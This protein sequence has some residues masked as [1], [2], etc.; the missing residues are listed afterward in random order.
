MIRAWI[1]ACT[2]SRRGRAQLLAFGLLMLASVPAFAV[3]CSDFGG[4]LDGNFDSAPS[5]MQIDMHCTIRNFPEGNELNTNFSFFTQPGQTDERWIVIFDNVVHTGNMSC[6]ATHEHKIWFTNGSST[7]IKEGCQN[8][9][10]PV[11]KIDKRNPDGQN[12]ARV[13]VPFTYTLTIPV[14][15]DPATSTVIN[16]SGSPNELHSVIVWDDLNETGAD[17]T[18]LGHV[19][20]WKDSGIPV[21]HTFSNVGG[22]LTFIIDPIIPAETQMIIELTVVLDDTPANAPGTQFVNTAKWEFGR[23]IDGEFF[24]PLPGEWGITEP[25]IIASPDLVVTKTGLATMNLGQLGSFTLDVHNA[26]LTDAWDVTILD[27]LPDGASGGM[28]DFTPIIA[29]AQVFAADG[30]TPV[31]GKGPLVE[32]TDYTLGFDG[33]PTC[34][35][36]F[37]MQTPAARIGP[38]ERLIIEYQTK[39]DPDTQHGV[40]LTNVAGAIEWFDGPDS[41][42]V[43]NTVTRTLT[44][45]T[46]GTQDHEDE[47]TVTAALSGYFYEKTVEN[48][49]TGVSPA[50]TASPGDVLRYTLRLQTT[51]DAFNDLVFRDDLGALN[52]TPVFVPGTLALVPGSLP[53]GADASNTNPNGGTDGA[54]F[55]DVRNLD[56]PAWSEISIQFDIAV[57]PAAVEGTVATNQAELV[58]GGLLIAVSDDPNVNGQADPDVDGD[59]DPTRVLIQVPVPDPL[60]KERT[61]ATATIG[62]TFSY[63]ITVPSQPHEEPIYDVRILDDLS[64]SAADLRFVSV[65]KVSGSQP[66]TP[67]NIGTATSLVIVDP[68]VGIDIPAG[69]QI[70]VEITVV[71]E[72]TPGNVAGVTFTNTAGFT[73]NVVNNNNASQRSGDPGTS[74]PMTIVE[75]ELTLEKDGPAAMRPD[76]PATFTLDI[77]NIGEERAWGLVITDRLPNTASGGMCEAAPFDFTAQVYLA[78]GVTSVSAPLSQGTDFIVDFA[79][80]P[81][82]VVTITLS[83]AAATIGPDQRLI[84]TYQTTLDGDTVADASLTNVAGATRW[85]GLDPSGAG[86]DARTYTRIVTDGTVGILDHED[87]HTVLAQLAPDAL[88]KERTQPAATIGDPFSYRITV[89]AQPH[90][91]PLHDVRIVDELAASAADLRF[92]SVEKIAGSGAW[93]PVNTGTATNV[94][95][96]D[97]VNGIDIPAGEQIVLEITV[98]LE[99]TATNVAGL[100]FTN[101]AD[102]TFNAVDGDEATRLPGDAG[103]SAPMTI[104][105]PELTLEKSGPTHMRTGT[106]GTF[107]LNIHNVGETRAWGLT[108]IDLLPSTAVG[109]MCETPPSAFSAQV[110]AADGATPVSPALTQGS[111]FTVSFSGE[112]D[113]RLTF[114]LQSAAATIGPDERLIISYQAS[115]DAGS[116]QAAI[117]TNVAG[118]TEWFGLDPSDPDTSAD[119][120]TYTRTV[121]DGTVGVLDHQDAH[122]VLVQLAVLVFEKTVANVSRGQDPGTLATPG[123]TLR[124]RLRIENISDVEVS[125]LAV[126]DELDRLNDEPAFAAGTLTLI[127]IPPG[128]NV[129]NTS[130]T[131]GASGTGVLD[132]RNLSLGDGESA[133]IELEVQLAPVIANATWVT[134]QA[135]LLVSGFVIGVSDDPNVNGAADPL[136]SGD[137]DPTR[138]QIESAPEFEVHKVSSYIEGDPDVLLAGET[139]RYT[140]TVRNVG[141][142]HAYDAVLRDEVP[143]NTVYVPGST[144]LNGAAVP[145]GPSST[146]P[147]SAGIQL[148]AP[149]NST[150]GFLR[151]TPED[152]ASN[153]ATIVFDVVVNDDVMDGTVISNQ[154]FVSAPAG[155]VSD[156]PSDDP[157][158][159]VPDDPT[160]DVVGNLP[161]LYSVKTVALEVDEGSPGIVDPGDVLRYTIVIHND[162]SIPA[163]NVVLTDAVPANT[164]YV[165]NSLTLNGLSVGQPDGGVSPLASG[166]PVSSSDLT[167]PLPA[168]G[169]GAISPGEA[170]VVQFDVRVNDGVPSGTLI[171]NQGTVSSDELPNLL[172]D[173][174]G[175]PAT[176]PQP[177][178]VVVGDA[179]QLMITKQVAVIGGGPALAGSTLEYVVRVVN[180]AAVPAQAVVIT[181]DLDVPG[182]GQLTFVDQSAAMNGS[183]AGIA[184]AGSALTADYSGVNGELA[185]GAA[186][187]LRFRAVIDAGIDIGTTVINTADVSWNTP[188]QTASAS[189]AIDVGGI[190]G[191]AVLNGTAW[192]DTNFDK[193]LDSNENVLEGWTVELYRNSALVHTTQ[194]D[195]EGRYRIAGLAP[196]DATGDEYEILFRAP[197]AGPNTAMLG[198]ADSPFTDGLQRI[199]DIVAPSGSNL[200]DLNLPIDPNGVVYDSVLRTP[201]AG[202]VLTLLQASSATPVPAACLE[203]TNQQG[204]V[205][206]PGG[207]YK[208]TLDFGAPGCPSSGD[209]VIEITG[210][211]TGYLEGY[212]EI[213]P[214]LTDPS[215]SPFNVPGCPGSADD[216]V[217]ATANH[218]EATSSELAPPVSV[219][220]RTPGTSYYVHVTLDA[221]QLPGSGEL[222]NN[223]IPLDPELDG[224]VAITKTT[225]LVNVVRG[226]L[227]PYTITVNNV[228]GIDLQD[229]AIVDR[230]PAGFRYVEGSAR[231]DG[232]PTE[233]ETIGRELIWSGLDVAASGR[234]TIQLLL[235]VGAGVSEGEYVNRAQVVHALSGNALSGEASATVR[236]VPDP[237]FDCTDVMG[238]VFNDAN[239]NGVQDPGEPG[240]AGVRV[241]TARGL[242]ATTDEH[243]RFHFTCA[244]VPRE[245]RGSNFVLKLDDRTLPSG[246]RG[247]TELTRVARATRG[248]T[249]TINF[250]A[251]LHRVVGLDLADAVFEPDS[252]VMRPQWRPRLD[253]LLEELTR[254]PAVLRLSYLADIEDAQLVNRR[255]DLLK[256]E[257]TDAWRA[258]DCCY[259]LVIEPEVFWRLGAPPER[260]NER[261][262]RRR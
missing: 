162:A 172:T 191:V 2:G 243:G 214:P 136:V 92:V 59:E 118:A 112:P 38:N 217:A 178:V 199:S 102:F 231:L 259:D 85:F 88:L 135:Q 169:E 44:D 208:F 240:L 114:T 176:G 100:V 82:C 174:D 79:G 16:T 258:M 29:S 181:D 173:G 63:R 60:L 168:T 125:N 198:R 32:G 73:Y 55:L 43:R 103:A 248:K 133:V 61:Q 113:C 71:L 225:P 111:D 48:L 49:T 204:Q 154:G 84:V 194:T 157:R 249:L 94:V 186:I 158:T 89:P 179:Q 201:I 13:G 90:D 149:E 23:L 76:T 106:P 251:S 161:L 34:E 165:A 8:L 156:Q 109:G 242:A 166:I 46:P 108:V 93:T 18:Y 207:F 200:Q 196:N 7:A 260:P 170:A 105:E 239:R 98:V 51:E 65:A 129:S 140:L 22:L 142:D 45:G 39:L 182:P 54:G 139:L 226:Q 75:P 218:C 246:F 107:T 185:P 119:A 255:M 96:E 222:Y 134:N 138:I 31:P 221:S 56:I 234:Y 146:S 153:V 205:T 210:R 203:D 121:T 52:P 250:G 236:L 62:E 80:A 220:A 77:H 91:A 78:D 197:G 180:V 11:E 20:Y 254:S 147:L 188:A 227:V 244:I 237:T 14:L 155:G 257:I 35:L 5:Q 10:I 141:T 223:H 26:G 143:A 132:V 175:N 50:T 262:R 253:L 28:C 42:P 21:S 202:A 184:I 126:R 3:N 110:F 245:G 40:T 159:S 99:D 256:R 137:E 232:E 192:H 104:V 212:S 117:L 124:Y 216:A 69:E 68:G 238:K 86:N 215:T 67:V 53:P 122:T 167:P 163:T 101:T 171:I 4:L 30:V 233:P 206:P 130:A 193:A 19:A 187:V 148:N 6:N 41:D 66:W 127:S 151:A 190:P 247:S 24:Q 241:V 64:T 209:Y 115:L 235:A 224:A 160:R 144:I 70:V 87:A 57:D 97:P 252:I 123:E 150:P 9:L 128:A 17:L 116:E 1:R 15:F 261:R 230:F 37:A 229:V 213:I 58:H 211:P 219:R 183:T 72:D 228:L 47:H 33:A 131:G 152:T 164:T 81:V 83:S 95:I 27:L 145:D 195:I 177:T 189:A 74:E 120:R 36:T 12:T 25:M